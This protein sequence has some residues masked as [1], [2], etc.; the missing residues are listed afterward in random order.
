MSF[1]LE[2]F[3]A[4]VVLVGD[5]NPAIF[6]P[7]WLEK[8]QLLGAADAE[9]A[10]NNEGTVI[11]HQVTRF[12]TEWFV[13]QVL[14]QQ[15][16]ISSKGNVTDS[17]K[18]LVTGIFSLLIHTP[19]KGLGLNSTA[20]FKID[21]EENYH[22]IGNVLAPKDIWKSVFDK[23]THPGL[24]N[25]AIR[26]QP[27]DDEGKHTKDGNFK[28][29]TLQPSAN[30][31]NGVYFMINNHYNIDAINNENQTKAQSAIST[32][33]QDWN[34]HVIKSNEKFEKILAMVLNS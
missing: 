9:F 23:N 10:R 1:S 25:L 29:V 13:L 2:I 18:D 11:T 22:K 32:L 27:L 19:V 31:P 34:E 6:T 15:F 14:E 20:H 4:S 26:L 24:E 5:F 8:H 12:E 28:L 16:S 30:I 17:L 33:C 21:T 7:D 3:G